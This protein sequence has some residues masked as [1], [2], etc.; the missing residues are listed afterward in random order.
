MTAAAAGEATAFHCALCGARFT[1]GDQVCAACPL[2]AACDV[3]VCPSCG[4]QFPRASVLVTWLR[5]RFGGRVG[6]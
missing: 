5:R 6:R 3:V 4:F 1:H 2:R